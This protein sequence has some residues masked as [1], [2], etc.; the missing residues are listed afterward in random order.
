MLRPTCIILSLAFLAMG[1]LGITEM[2]PMFTADLI[3]VNIGE[4][5]IGGIGL[6]TGA[7][8]RKE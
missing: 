1:I 8:V 7:F 2:V 6:V 4:I 3:Y 5:V